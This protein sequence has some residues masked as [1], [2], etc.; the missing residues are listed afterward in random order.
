MRG[1]AEPSRSARRPRRS[2]A[3]GAAPPAARTCGARPASPPGAAADRR[4]RARARATRAPP[5]PG[6]PA[7][8][9]GFAA[10]AAD[11]GG[12]AAPA[13]PRAHRAG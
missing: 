1:E 8:A 11:A 7:R 2:F 13:S 4:A 12:A 3:G 10:A 5:A 9:R 6:V